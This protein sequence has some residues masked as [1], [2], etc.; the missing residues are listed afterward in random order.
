MVCLFLYIN[1]GKVSKPTITCEVNDDGSPDGSGQ[2]ATLTCSAE[3][4]QSQLM[5]FDWSSHGKQLQP[6]LHHPN[7]TITLGD[8]RDHEMYN[9]SVSNPLTMESAVFLA[10]D[11]YT[12]KTPVRHLLCSIFITCVMEFDIL[13][14]CTVEI[15]LH[16]LMAMGL[17]KINKRLTPAQN[18]RQLICG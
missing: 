1:L 3:S 18:L 11:C 15:N 2:T 12:G 4:R 10:K 13:S 7:L 17:I 16:K 8:E 9:C 14:K 6:G 5:K